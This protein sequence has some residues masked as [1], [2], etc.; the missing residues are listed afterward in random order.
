M[1]RNLSFVL[2]LVLGISVSAHVYNE[3]LDP[4]NI[5]KNQGY[6][7]IDFTLLDPH[8]GTLDEWV[9]LV[10]AIHAKGITS[11][12]ITADVSYLNVTAPFDLN[13][14][15]V[16]WKLPPLTP[17][18]FE[19][20]PDFNF[21]NT[22]NESCEYPTF[23][24]DDASI[25]DPQKTGCYDSNFDQYGDIEAFGVFPDWQRQLAKFASVQDRLR[26]WRPATMERLKMFSCLTIQALDIDGIR[27]DK[28]TQVTVAALADWATSTRA[29]AVKYGKNNFFIPGEITGG[30][31]FGA[32]YIGRGRTPHNQPNNFNE[33]I[34]LTQDQDQ[35]FLRNEGVAALDSAA[36]HYS[37]YRSLSRFLGMDGNLNVAYDIDINFITAWNEMVINDEFLNSQTN[38]FDPRHMY[39]TTNQDVFR[40]PG[41][42]NGTLRQQ[43]GQFVTTLLMPGIPLLYY[44]EEQAF[45]IMDNG[46]SNYLYGR[47][48]MFSSTAWQRHGCYK[49]GSS[50]YYNMPYDKALTGCDDDWNAL[51][52]FDP[53]A[54]ARR[55]I[56]AMNYLRTQFPSLQDGFT[57]EQLGN[58]THFI[59]LPGSNVTQ[60]ELGM[61]TVS[62]APYA[63]Q[64][65]TGSF[66]ANGTISQVVW[67]IYTNENATQEYTYDCGTTNWI[68]SPY[69][70]GTTIRNLLYPYEEKTLQ[71]SKDSF[72]KNG[73][74]PW[75]GCLGSI[76]LDPF[77]Y[78]AFVPV[79][80]WV[81]QRPALTKFTPGHD[82]RIVSTGDTIDVTLEYDTEMNCDA[83]LAALT[84]TYSGSST[85]QPTITGTCAVITDTVTAP[86]LNSVAPSYWRFTG[87]ISNAGDGIYEINIGSF[88]AQ[89]GNIA[90]GST[91]HLLLRY[92]QANNPMI[93]PLTADYSDTLLSESSGTYTVNHS[94]PGADMFRYSGNFGQSWTAWEAYS[95]TST[96]NATVFDGNW[97]K[98]Q[99]VMI[100]YWSKIGG[101]AAAI[102]HGDVNWTGGQRRWPQLLARGSFNTWGYDLGAASA[103]SQQGDSNWALPFMAA[104]PSYIQLNV[105]GFDTYYY[106]DTDGDGIIDRLPPNSESANYL[107]I[108]VP[109]SPHLAWT[110]VVN[111]LTGEWSTE[112]IGNQNLNIA[113]F[114]LLL[115]VP[116]LTA[117]AAAATFRYSFYSIKVNKWGMKPSKETTYFPIG[118]DKKDATFNE[119]GALV[120][121]EKAAKVPERLIGWPEDVNKRRKVLIATL[122]YE[123]LDWKL[124]VKIGG[125]G[126]MSTLMGKAMTDVDMIW[127]IPKV[128]DLEYPQGDYAEPIE[129]IIFGEP[130][131]I[132]VETHQLDNITYVI[133]DSPVF[134][135]Q[136]KSDPY[137]QRMDDLSSAIFYSTWNQAIAETIRRY[138]IIDIYHINDYHG[139]LA[140][141][142]L[143]PQIMPVCLSLHNAE[144]QG[145][146]PLRTKDEMKEVCAAFN[147]PKEVCS[148]YVQFGNTFNLLHAAASFIS[149][150]QKSIGV[151]GVSDKY[152]KRSWAR[153]PALWTLRNIDSLP[154]PDPTDIAALDAQPIAVDKIEVDEVSEAKRPEFKRQAQE[155]AGIKQDPDADL[156][157][158][159][160]RWSKQ[161]GVDLI[162]DVMP[163]L[164]DKKPKIQLICV[165]PVI[166]LYGRFA[167]EK[168]ARLMEMFPDRVFSKPE[169]TSLPPYLFSGADF[170]LI[171]SRDEPFG[172][173][174]VEFGR[175]GA[176]G[177]GARLGGLGLMPGW[178][179]RAILRA[180]SAVQ[181]FPVVEWRQR[182]ED[183]QRRSI[184]VSRAMAGEHAWAY[185]IAGQ[186]P[187]S[188]FYNHDAGSNLSLQ[189][190]GFPRSGTPDSSAPPSPMPDQH[191]L[192]AHS[193]LG[194]PNDKAN[195]GY[196]ENNNLSA[197]GYHKR[198][199]HGE[200]DRR[201]DRNSAESF[202]DEDPN[203]SPLYYDRQGGGKKFI[204]GDDESERY[205]SQASSDVGDTTVVGSN[206]SGSRDPAV[207]QSY[208]NFLAAA[209]RQIAKQSKGAKDPFLEHRQSMDSLSG[210]P[211]RPFNSHSR[212]SSFDSISSIMDE[213]GGSSPLNK[214]IDSNLSADNS[215]GDL[216]IERFLMKSEK[217]FFTEVKREKISSM[218]IRS[219]RDSFLGQS[220]APSMVEGFRP[221]SPYSMHDHDDTMANDHHYGDNSFEENG[222]EPDKRMTRLQ[223]FMQ[224]SL[225][226]W[227]LYTIIISLGQLLSATSFQLTLLTGSNTQTAVDLYIICAV[228]IVATF[229]WY[230]LFRMRPSVWCLSAPWLAFAIAFL[231]IGFPSLHGVFTS[232]RK[233]I[234]K[235]ATWVYAVASSAGFLFFGLNFGEEAGAA[236]EVW[237]MRACVV[238]G[239][240]QIWVSALW[241][242]GYTLNGT[243]PTSYVVPRTII[244]IV[245]PLAAVSL[246]F[247][248]LMFWGVPDYYR[249][250][251]RKLWI[252]LTVKIPPYVPNFFK[253]LARRKLVIWFFIAEILKDYWLSGPYGRNWQF[254]WAGA[255]VPAWATVIMIA[256]FFIGV[257]GLLLG[258]LIKYSKV[259]SWLLPVFA[260]GLGCPRWCQMFW[261]V[262]GL[263]LYIP[264]A[265]SAG[266]YVSCC[267]WLWLGVLDAIQGVGLGMILLQTLSRLH[268]CATL[269]GA[270]LIGS[271]VVM[272]ARATAPDKVGPGNVFPNPAFWN[273]S[274]GENNPLKH[275]EFWLCLV[276]QAIIPIGFSWFFRKE[277]LNERLQPVW[278][279]IKSH[280]HL[281]PRCC[282]N[283]PLLD[284]P[285]RT[286]RTLRSAPQPW[287]ETLQ[288]SLPRVMA[289]QL[290]LLG[291]AAAKSTTTVP[292]HWYLDLPSSTSVIHVRRYH[293]PPPAP[294]PT[295]SFDSSISKWRDDP[296]EAAWR[297]F[298]SSGDS[299][300]TAK[301]LQY[302]CA[303]IVTDDED[304]QRELWCFTAREP[305]DEDL[306]MTSKLTETLPRLPPITPSEVLSCSIHGHELSCLQYGNPIHTRGRGKGKAAGPCDITFQ[307][308]PEVRVAWEHF[309]HAVVER[310]AW[311]AGQRVVM[312]PAKLSVGTTPPIRTTLY[313]TSPSRLALNLRPNIRPRCL[314]LLP[315]SD[316]PAHL[317]PLSLSPLGLPALYVNHHSASS[318]Q[319]ARLSSLFETF[320]GSTWRNGRADKRLSAQMNNEIFSNWSIYWVPLIPASDISAILPSHLAQNWQQS[321]GVLTVWPTH[322]VETLSTASPLATTAPRDP[323]AILGPTSTDDMMETA[324]SL[325]DF[326][327][328]Y[329]EPE[330]VEP[331][332][333]DDVLEDDAT[334]VSEKSEDHEDA[335]S[336]MD[337][338]FSSHSVPSEKDKEEE[339]IDPFD[340]PE[341][342]DEAAVTSSAIA[343][344][345]VE[346]ANE[347][348]LFPEEPDVLALAAVTED[349]FNFFDSPPEAQPMEID[350]PL[351]APDPKPGP[352]ELEIVEIV[353]QRPQIHPI[354]EVEEPAINGIL[355]SPS[356]SPQPVPEPSIPSPPSPSRQDL[357]LIPSPFGAVNLPS[358][359]ASF[360]YNPPTPAPSPQDL[361]PYLLQRL[362]PTT[363]N[364]ALNYADGWDLSSE[365]SSDQEED[366][367]TGAP[368]TPESDED[369]EQTSTTKVTP[370]L[371][372][373]SFMDDHVEFGDRV[374]LGTEWFALRNKGLVLQS[375]A[376]NW[377]ASWASPRST[378]E[379]PPSPAPS[380]FPSAEMASLLDWDRFADEIIANRWFR[381]AW[382]SP[383]AGPVAHE[384]KSFLDEGVPL[385]NCIGDKDGKS[386]ISHLAACSIHTGFT[387]NVMQLSIAAL[388]YWRELGLQPV[389]GQKN[390][391]AYILCEPFEAQA[392]EELLRALAENYQACQLGDHKPGNSSVSKNGIVVASPSE[393][394]TIIASIQQ[395]STESTV[396]YIM[397][398]PSTS[399]RDISRK[400]FSKP[401]KHSTSVTHILPSF[402]LQYHQ[403]QSICFDVY[404][405]LLRSVQRVMLRG[406]RIGGNPIHV[407][408]PVF[409]LAS[410]SPPTPVLTVSWP[411]RSYDL[412]NKWRL[413]HGAYSF[414]SDK[415]VLIAS[416][417]DAQGEGYRVKTWHLEPQT[418]VPHRLAMLWG[419]FTSFATSTAIEWRL[420]VCSLGIISKHEIE[421]WKKVSEFR[422]E[423]LTVLMVD[424]PCPITRPISRARQPTAIVPSILNDPMT[425]ILDESLLARAAT[426]AHRLPV[427]LPSKETYFPQS[428][429]VLNVSTPSLSEH[430]SAVYHLTSHKPVPGNENEDVVELLKKE[431]YKLVCLG[432]MR[433]GYESCL[434]AHLESVRSVMLAIGSWETE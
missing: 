266:P 338:L 6:S 159:V 34:Y 105:W 36:F 28:A 93:F 15:E 17:W 19:S 32:L 351:I 417:M 325:F 232:H 296:L 377:N 86:D 314:P 303:V 219:S 387:G 369:F 258:I 347:A 4:W 185:D 122:E 24:L 334:P 359:L 217:A 297:A 316:Q 261:A 62:R 370:T 267:L 285:L 184:T 115:I 380:P 364:P 362:A 247:S 343:P 410:D 211:S 187:P 191:H 390:V 367:Y 47:Q 18:G 243:D 83:L 160:G 398:S 414:D 352:V 389:S 149:H 16:Q 216:C 291:G 346:G 85:T 76:T 35:F 236:T 177:V 278:R 290:D 280:I 202:Y 356:P 330:T 424:H 5:N 305:R 257:W 138:P 55:G 176:L 263:G 74:A 42:T 230:T 429:F 350:L 381:N 117:F 301:V 245:W 379:L 428:S 363:T 222:G 331:M 14:H 130:Y 214:A 70:S 342:V 140:P 129:V 238:Q 413:I 383:P 406:N 21:S 340:L 22:Y 349:D 299:S 284:T 335:D 427:F 128:K 196:F 355:R 73:M 228:F 251:S 170:A 103:F 242:W 309:G 59:Q 394:S 287:S 399:S 333:E 374:C 161:K 162:A 13:E 328:H 345:V 68:S 168:L 365:V 112:P 317:C 65:G 433:F 276:C 431:F 148:K 157:V 220:K 275:Y 416:A 150:H 92:G 58:W 341:I 180:R 415:N 378:T 384:R 48:P 249:Q 281:H 104:W 237:I 178:E 91:D 71:D 423:P 123:I 50:Q 323:P 90:T 327:T 282:N 182:L 400:L 300:E 51:D 412:F 360:P 69:Q 231:L 111:D 154:N 10:D 277:Q 221:E 250:V 337:D 78:K 79:D 57:V 141:L 101:T 269:A 304:S 43:L 2:S 31:T 201:Q 45:Y 120:T 23:W 169:F 165:G 143:L 126:V 315:G 89:T 226:G 295:G 116:I 344:S 357:A 39:G 326:Y 233:I 421:A 30:D 87:Q 125:L 11:R 12:A 289:A 137:P 425:I 41:L 205:A 227:P 234:T 376:C 29:C 119:K 53:T 82:A 206:A 307:A 155:W 7:A 402:A 408:S 407:P 44:G 324:A 127:V 40:W 321:Q 397:L 193:P 108:S 25:V 100:Q 136:T 151:A 308:A 265:G 80:Q 373:G 97:W 183:F 144:F 244:Y 38:K 133:L 192:A 107:N 320:L 395:E 386:G 152:G 3:T 171:P 311:R 313:P 318:P 215:K 121:N 212:V 354:L 294:D 388:R 371:S 106:G 94:A 213:K 240:Q 409:T 361:R 146:W 401:T 393:W 156:F 33:S 253:T 368:P 348:P 385:I 190:G 199:D 198:F 391:L 63:S 195:N 132:E 194:S 131:L 147:I 248:Y 145:L 322:L 396:F 403:L 175:K 283:I 77:S 268:V 1:R 272:I 189:A 56:K 255:G 142:Y 332:L 420:V 293:I 262:S 279:E 113:A 181:R 172:L 164:L 432:R 271:A 434:P 88:A 124:K 224:R 167:A 382:D 153:Y 310:L 229:V 158:F 358:G 339:P 418:P 52:H 298:H 286:A 411:I 264:W 26:E 64:E 109:P 27:I 61:W 197:A 54:E 239:L 9:A 353:E 223:I 200:R 256:I 96:L 46:A 204:T 60:T 252:V 306:V 84:I 208:D 319:D 225:A 72:Y 75:R 49:L 173:V 241:Y 405:R 329:K 209:N 259:H 218:S 246:L 336:D 302:V 95:A 179:E 254:L 203:S 210:A 207:A 67:L 422:T 135:A 114:V 20:Y 163:S 273:V 188:G 404:N 292:G 419:F 186:S 66:T 372:Q 392:A 270:Q 426:F 375:L 430:R 118:A 288:S 166:D 174:A 139:A 98:G 99:H 134:R 8:Y 274:T 260:V 366:D 312:R 102:M 81:Q 110:V 37:I 235:V